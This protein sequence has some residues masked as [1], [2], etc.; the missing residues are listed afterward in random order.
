MRGRLIESALLVFAQHGIDPGVIDKVIKTAAV[1][2]GTFYNYFR[3]NDE[4][5]VAVAT[6]VSNEILRIV[7]PVVHQQPD[8]ASRVACGIRLVFELSRANPMLAEFIV[9]GGPSSLRYGSLVTEVVPRD[10]E[11]AINSGQFEVQ[12][13]RLAFDLLL[14]PVYLAFHT[15][16]SGAIDEDYPRNLARGILLAL[17]TQRDTVD[18]ICQRS[19]EPVDIPPDSLFARTRFREHA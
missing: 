9:K 19:L 17:G 11:L 14:G 6:E 3:T 1:S 12:D 2:R 4:L 18:E 15:V 7:D 16:V 8:A 10:L 5:F 13:I